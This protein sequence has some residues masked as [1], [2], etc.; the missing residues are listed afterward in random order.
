M[1]H[2]DTKTFFHNQNYFGLDPDSV[3]FFS[4]GALPCL[5]LPTD[6]TNS[7]IT[8]KILMENPHSC[9][10]APDGNGGIYTAM[11]QRGI[12]N[13]MY[14]RNI[15]HVHVFSIDNVLTL[16]ADPTFIG[17]CIYQNADVGNKVVWKRD[18]HEKIGV[19][20]FKDGKPSVV[21]YSEL[22]TEMAELVT[23]E[24]K[25]VYGAGNICNHYYTLNFITDTILPN[26]KTLFHIAEKKIPT[27]DET[28]QQTITPTTTNNGIKLESFIFDAFQFSQSMTIL[29][30][31]RED[32]FSPVKNAPGSTNDCPDTARFMI[33]E[34]A[35]RW[36]RD[37]GAILIETKK[38]A[39]DGNESDNNHNGSSS[40]STS[41]CC[42]I[43]PLVSYA[44]EGLEKYHGKEI[45]CPFHIF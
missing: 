29:E 17:Y 11:Q 6:N 2:Q 5:A 30:V 12:L 20:A 19:M 33:S 28:T 43:S 27:W 4:Q 8:P 10:M 18:A 25:L 34:R 16:P 15:Q 37:A 44:G 23:D 13:D 9:A 32:E 40:I 7:T 14:H 42:E 24:Q 22:S 31:Q 39:N 45:Q 35:K 36:L 41:D 1:N 26:M 38:N 3:F 21:E